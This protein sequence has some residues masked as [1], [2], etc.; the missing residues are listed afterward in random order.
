[1]KAFSK[2]LFLLQYLLILGECVS[3]S[4]NLK[5]Q[6][7]Q[8]L[9]YFSLPIFPFLDLL[10]LDRLLRSTIG[11]LFSDFPLK[12]LKGSSNIITFRLLLIEFVLKLERH[13]IVSI[14]SLLQLNSSLMDLGKN[15]EVFVFIHGCLVSLID[16]YVIFVS[17]LFDFGLHHAVM[18]V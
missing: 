5:P 17:H 11:C 16:E 8:L 4:Q 3:G 1:M 14:L 13:L 12:L 6:I 7:L 10:L 18:I 9:C 2:L 15:V